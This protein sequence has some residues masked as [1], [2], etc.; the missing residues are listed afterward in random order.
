MKTSLRSSER[1]SA[2][3]RVRLPP[4]ASKRLALRL[5]AS[6]CPATSSLLRV[7]DRLLLQHLQPGEVRSAVDAHGSVLQQELHQLVDDREHVGVGGVG[8][9][10]QRQRLQLGSRCRRRSRS[11]PARPAPT[12]ARSGKPGR[13]RCARRGR[14]RRRRS[15]R[16]SWRC[17][18]WRSARR[19]RPGRGSSPWRRS[20]TAAIAPLPSLPGA[21]AESPSRS[22]QTAP[23]ASARVDRGIDLRCARRG[24]SGRRR[25]HRRR[26]PRRRRRGR[27]PASGRGTARSG[28]WRSGRPRR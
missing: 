11:S 3:S 27:S 22:R 15:P 8:L 21:V 14:R 16:P 1:S 6:S 2:K 10:D 7:C 12:A 5:V 23:P 13:R 24:R 25:R 19:S 9:L 18:P 20:A 17:P 26:G 28:R 4:V